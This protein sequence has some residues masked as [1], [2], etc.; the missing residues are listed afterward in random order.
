MIKKFKEYISEGFWKSGISRAK[1]NI[2]RLEDHIDSNI[3]TLKPIDLGYDIPILF[4]DNDLWIGKK[5]E[6]LYKEFVEYLPY[7]EK[8]GWRLPTKNEIND[9]LLYKDGTCLD[10]QKYTIDRYYRGI[11][12]NVVIMSKDNG[13]T[14]DFNYEGS[15]QVYMN[16][17]YYWLMDNDDTAQ[18]GITPYDTM[19]YSIYYTLHCEPC[20]KVGNVY[21]RIRLVKDKND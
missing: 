14:I 17:R 9:Y 1:E 21:R 20:P 10:K 5:S 12:C 13:E 3:K 6:W 15:G 4:S 11:R 8:H 7:I 18:L 19:D 16:R 2:D